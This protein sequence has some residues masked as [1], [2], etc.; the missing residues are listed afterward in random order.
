MEPEELVESGLTLNQATVYLELLKHP[1]QSGGQIAKKIGIDRSFVYGILNSLIDKGLVVYVTKGNARLFSHSNPE[2]LLKEVDE[3]RLKIKKI[4]TSL[5]EI[6]QSPQ[7][8]ISVQVYE[9]KDGL[10][11]FIRDLIESDSFVTFGGGGKFGIASLLE[12]LKY[13]YPHYLK[14]FKNKKINGKLIT[15]PKNQELCR[16]AFEQYPL[17]IK[18]LPSL[19]SNVSITIANNK[20]AIYS[21]EEKPYVIVIEDKNT[22][23]MFRDYFDNLW[24]LL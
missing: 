17:K 21:A 23:N 2:N 8:Q 18:T 14:E 20:V 24:E 4:V 3:K 15:S 22:S 13:E 6:K 5:K 16:K 10:K 11:A 12:T 19:N 9:G 7:S 1:E